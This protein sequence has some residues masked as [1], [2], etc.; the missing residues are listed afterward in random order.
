MLGRFHYSLPTALRAQ[1]PPQVTTFKP[2]IMASDSNP[3]SF[4][5]L[6]PEPHAKRQIECSTGANSC[7]E[8]PRFKGYTRLEGRPR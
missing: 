7:Q 1:L 3:F 2:R 5:R 8:V 6:S 4:G